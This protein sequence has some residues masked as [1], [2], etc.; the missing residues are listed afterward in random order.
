MSE[1]I[2]KCCSAKIK[3]L[4][5]NCSFYLTSPP[6]PVSYCTNC[7]QIEPE[8]IDPSEIEEEDDKE[9]ADD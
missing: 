5:P 4:I 1:S 9:A 8:E 6:D 7:G 2:S 3:A